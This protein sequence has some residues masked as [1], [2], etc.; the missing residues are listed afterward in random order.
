VWPTDQNREAWERR[1]NP[2]RPPARLPDGVRERLGEVAGKHV[3]HLPAR[4][5]DVTAQLIELGALVTGIDPAEESLAAAREHVP[6][7]A[8]FQAELHDIPLQLRR[9]RFAVVFAG[10][11]TLELAPDLGAFLATAAAALRKGG[12]LVLCD[13]HPVAGCVEPVGLRWRES[14]F[15][16]G[17]RRAGEIVTEVLRSELAVE[18]VAELPPATKDQGDPR[19]PAWLLV[20]ARKP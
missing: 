8:F 19:I 6:D 15:E 13:R 18:E 11:G 9:R 17:R 16:E 14:Y 10:E 3:L 5:G 7:A 12:Q 4:E 20:R 2:P 1:F